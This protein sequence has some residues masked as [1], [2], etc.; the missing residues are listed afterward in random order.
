VIEFDEFPHTSTRYDLGVGDHFIMKNEN[1]YYMQGHIIGI[2]DDTRGV[3]AD[4]VHFEYQIYLE[5]RTR[6]RAL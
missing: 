6:F 3:D 5:G 2:K 4:G 1:G